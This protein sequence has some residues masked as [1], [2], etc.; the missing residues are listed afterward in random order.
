MTRF[1]LQ[2]A[3]GALACCLALVLA[4]P[5]AAQLKPEAPRVKSVNMTGDPR[6]G[7]KVYLQSCWSCHGVAG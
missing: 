6:A 3:S 2:L 1:R 5:A 4:T 7:E